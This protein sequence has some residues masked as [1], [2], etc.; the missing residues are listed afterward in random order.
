MSPEMARPHLCVAIPSP[1]SS[2]LARF[3]TMT[4]SPCQLH[5][6]RPVQHLRFAV[7]GDTRPANEDDTAGTNERHRHHLLGHRRVEPEPSFVVS[8]GDYQFASPGGYES[9]TQLDLYMQARARSW[10]AAAAMATMSAPASPTQTAGRAIATESPPTSRTSF[11]RCSG[12]RPAAP[13]Y[14]VHVSAAGVPGRASS[15][16]SQP[17]H[18]TMRRG[19]AQSDSCRSDDVHVYR[20]ARA[21]GSEHGSRTTPSE[22]ILGATPVT[23]MLSGHTHT[24]KHSGNRIVVGNGGAPLTGNKGY[25]F[26][27][28]DQRADGVIVVD[29][30]DSQTMQADPDFHFAVTPEGIL[31]E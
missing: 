3:T 6:R 15:S 17:T 28:V 8:T 27:V 22:A 19:L 21:R 11:P 20:S 4:V 26:L 30:I 1:S 29:E 2:S 10:A 7:T 13:Y 31:T 25:G 16:S 23:L 12:H 24:Y 18:G 14:V 5:P 9:A